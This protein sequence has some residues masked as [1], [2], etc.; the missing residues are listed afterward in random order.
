MR[1]LAGL[2]TLGAQKAIESI[3]ASSPMWESMFPEGYFTFQLA[4]RISGMALNVVLLT[5]A[6]CLLRRRTAARPLHMIYAALQIVLV[7]VGAII[8]VSMMSNFTD[9]TQP[10]GGPVTGMRASMM[11]GAVW[12]VIWG[13]PY[14]FFL[15]IW[16]LR[17]S[18]AKDVA[19]WRA[20][21]AEMQ[22]QYPQQ[23]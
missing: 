1:A 19:S 13:S 11:F 17:A 12:G 2:V 5:A 22:Q 3:G 6:I 18:I 20:G 9:S 16:F 14:P 21:P 15:L 8:T 4:H 10:P 7:S 23:L